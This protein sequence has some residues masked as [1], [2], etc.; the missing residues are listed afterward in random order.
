MGDTP[1]RIIQRVVSEYLDGDRVSLEDVAD[2]IL[3][4]MREP[5]EA[6]DD[7]GGDRE[8]LGYDPAPAT[9]WKAMIDVALKERF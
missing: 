7:A 8:K 5:T 1:K 4:E 6:M 9:V 2:A 3:T